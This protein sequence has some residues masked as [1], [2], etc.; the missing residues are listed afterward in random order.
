M[1]VYTCVLCVSVMCEVRGR[2]EG[3]ASVALQEKAA[4]ALCGFFSV[5]LTMRVGLRKSLSG[6]Q[7]H[8]SSSARW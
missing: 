5:P 1:H 8:D 4:V 6:N 3:A 2:G 7:V